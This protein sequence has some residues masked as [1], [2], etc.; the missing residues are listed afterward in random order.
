MSSVA[1]DYQLWSSADSVQP[2]V[3]PVPGPWPLSL[4]F[5]LHLR[6][7][8]ASSLRKVSNWSTGELHLNK[9]VTKQVLGLLLLQCFRQLV[10][11]QFSASLREL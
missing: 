8:L 7:S 11:V 3:F 5:S 4:V 6:R 2:R 1:S 9:A 10:Q